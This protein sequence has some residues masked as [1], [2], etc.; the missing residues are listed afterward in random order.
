MPEPSE[1]DTHGALAADAS[2]W[3]TGTCA[4]PEESVKNLCARLGA[5]DV[6]RTVKGRFEDTLPLWRNRIGVI[7]LLHMDG[8]W[9]ASTKAILENLYDH[10]VS[11]GFIQVDDY[12][13]WDGCRRAIHEFEESRNIKFSLQQIDG[14]GVCFGRPDPWR[15]NAAIPPALVGEFENILAD[16]RHIESQMSVNELFALF[17]AIRSYAPRKTGLVRFVEIG[18]WAGASLNLMYRTI[19]LLSR[20]LQGIAIEP[21][22]RPQFYEVL[23]AL[24]PHVVH[25]KAFSHQAVPYLKEAFARDGILPEIILVDG[26]HAYESVRRDILDYYPLLAPGGI[27]VFHDFLPE[28]NDENREAIYSHHGG[29]EPGIRRACIELMEQ[30][31]HS[32]VLDLPLLYPD[33]PTQTQPHL[34]IIPQVRSTIRAYRKTGGLT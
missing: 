19:S 12:G 21:E 7:S 3:G 30:T 31:N 8:D 13:Y 27:M 25:L 17:Y 11:K 6:L 9:Y 5:L 32:E 24:Q 10:V 23:K 22:G 33:D 4:A 1:F 20:P 34:P 15:V 18:S 14:T 2:G 16:S 26:D 28:I 29:R